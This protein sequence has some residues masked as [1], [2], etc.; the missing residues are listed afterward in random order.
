M[1]PLRGAAQF[2]FEMGTG[3][4]TYITSGSVYVLAAWLGLFARPLDAVIAA[5][6]FGTGRALPNLIHL[7]SGSDDKTE[8]DRAAVAADVF[9]FVLFAVL[10]SWEVT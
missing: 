8:V 6:A 10:A 3:V 1:T 9:A 2:G 5:A 4:L 7:S